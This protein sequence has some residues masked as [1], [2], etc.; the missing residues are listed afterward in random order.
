MFFT[1]TTLKQHAE[2][3]KE[4][5]QT[6][7]RTQSGLVKEVIEIAG[8]SPSYFI[9]IFLES[10]EWFQATYI[11]VL[12]T[13]NN[14]VAHL[15]VILRCKKKIFIFRESNNILCKVSPTSRVMLQIPTSGP[16]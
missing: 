8:T 4:V 13:L 12:E 3:F 10:N 16:K 1:T 15:D 7:A 9:I 14:I 5:S 2:D 11:P 6:Y